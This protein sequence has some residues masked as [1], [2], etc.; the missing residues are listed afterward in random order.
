VARGD[1]ERAVVV[2]EDAGGCTF[3][4]SKAIGIEW[5]CVEVPSEDCL[6]RVALAEIGTNDSAEEKKVRVFFEVA[7]SVPLR[8]TASLIAR[9]LGGLGE[10]DSG[11]HSM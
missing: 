5:E 9:G 2:E 11:L 7:P 3:D 1:S 8:S 10:P 6:R 4:R